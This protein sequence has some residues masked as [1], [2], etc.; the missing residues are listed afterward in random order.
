MIDDIFPIVLKDLVPQNG[1]FHCNALL[2]PPS[3]HFAFIVLWLTLS[4]SWHDV[5]KSDRNVNSP[6][7]HIVWRVCDWVGNQRNFIITQF[8]RSLIALCRI[9]HFLL[10]SLVINVFQLARDHMWQVS[11]LAT[12]G[13]SSGISGIQ[14]KILISPVASTVRESQKETAEEKKKN[15]KNVGGAAFHQMGKSICVFYA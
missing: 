9:V 15:W 4:I 1:C 13:D 3:G 6:C 12:Y 5:G 8:T 2:A 14:S 10:N 7:W 11:H